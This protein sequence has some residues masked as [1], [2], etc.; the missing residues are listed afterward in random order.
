[1]S[2][3]HQSAYQVILSTMTDGYAIQDQTFTVIDFNQAA[4]DILGLTSEDYKGM[5]TNDLGWECFREDGSRI[6]YEEFPTNVMLASPNP[7]RSTQVL[8]VRHAKSGRLVWLQLNTI[9]F[10]NMIE[11][12]PRAVLSTFSDV[13]IQVAEKLEL[14]KN[15]Q[16][17]I[18]TQAVA[19]IGSWA[20]SPETGISRW[21]PE[22]FRLWGIPYSVHAPSLEVVMDRI[23][24]EDHHVVTSS[25]TTMIEGTETMTYRFR[26]VRD[27]KI[28]WVENHAQGIVDEQGNIIQ[29]HGTSQNITKRVALEA[30]N[31]F[32]MDTLCIGSWKL[33]LR[34]N[35]FIWDKHCYANFQ[36]DPAEFPDPF[37]AWEKIIHPD[38]SDM[39]QERFST[40]NFDGKMADLYFRIL[41]PTGEVRYIG[42]KMTVYRDPSGK[43]LY[44]LGINWDRTS[45]ALL[46]EN[47]IKEHARGIENSKLASLATMATGVAHEINNPLTL[48]SCSVTVLKK[49]LFKDKLDRD[50]LLENLNDIEGTV[51]R[52][53]H[54]IASL[55]SLSR[56]TASEVRSE[57]KFKDVL[58]DVLG[59][60]RERY[61]LSGVSVETALCPQAQEALLHV[62]RVQIIQVFLNLFSNSFDAVADLPEKWIRVEASAEGK[63]LKIR[64]LDSGKGIEPSIAEKIFDPFFTTKDI[65]RGAGLGLGQSKTLIEG[66]GGELRLDKNSAHTCFVIEIGLR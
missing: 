16:D 10:D 17:L 32:V 48:I 9:P 34:Q 45:E 44:I 59:L 28:I 51:D 55:R 33:D 21:S 62:R 36:I 43:V 27:E 24:P 53:S 56:D 7:L 31:K 20:F 58:S 1:M 13:T 26:L 38:D 22:M 18:K 47:V 40:L 63:T 64:I 23:H 60:F 52:I 50:F 14:K 29:L 30:E 35:K 66:N 39:V 65:G 41:T 61:M 15:Q 2:R 25:I 49:M 6:T 12:S 57:V 37:T 42:S 4:L 5:S 11:G 19:K 8:G 46:Q 3:I 54:T